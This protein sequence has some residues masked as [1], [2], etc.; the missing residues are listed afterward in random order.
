MVWDIKTS[1]D[2][3]VLEVTYGSRDGSN[4]GECTKQSFRWSGAEFAQIGPKESTICPT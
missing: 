2:S 1:H 4:D 3:D